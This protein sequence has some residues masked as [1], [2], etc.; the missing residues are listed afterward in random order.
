MIR[1]GRSED[2]PALVALN[3]A[4]VPA[5]NALTNADF[6]KFAAIADLFRVIG[7][8]SEPRA[9]LIGLQPG[10][11]YDSLNYRWFEA[12][13]ERFLYVDRVVVH[14]DQR[15]A[16]LGAMLYADFENAARDLDIPRL[17]CE[18]NL[19]PANP[20]SMRF[21]ERLGFA[22]VGTQEAGGKRVQFLVKE[23]GR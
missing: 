22:P 4:A 1:D 10:R 18:V 6:E 23:L 12:R 9:L 16:G 14:A 17:A 8:P 21:H 5:V 20:G 2:F 15:G 7:P 13:H 3:N 19:R 11:A